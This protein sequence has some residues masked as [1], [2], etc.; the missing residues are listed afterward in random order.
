MPTREA[1]ST[2]QAADRDDDLS[3][4]HYR[5][6]I[7]DPISAAGLGPLVDDARFDV[8][9]RLGLKGDALADALA[10][11]DAV[12]VRSASRITREAL[13][14]A[15][16][17]RVIGRAGVGVDNIDVEAATERGIAVL[18][19]PSGNTVSA[20]ELAFALLLALARRVPAA[21]R[22]MKEGQWDRRS[23]GGIELYGKTLGLVGAGRIGAAVARR[24]K[25]F[26]MSVIAYDPFLTAERAE[27][28]DI[29]L[30]TLDGVIERG[31]IISLHVP[32]T[33]ATRNL[34]GAAELR[35][36]KP[37]AFIVNAARGGVV[38]EDALYRALTEG[39]I[40]GA[41]LDVFAEE[42]P[43]A[44]HP[45][46]SLPNVV[47]TPHLGAAT[48]E[49]QE[50]VAIE[51]AGAVRSALL[52]DDMSRAVNAPAIGGEAMRR[53]RPL[54]D[55][56]ER[57]G[58]LI[59]ALADGPVRRI[60]IRYSGD[61]DGALRPLTSAAMIGVL[62]G[63]LGRNAVNFVNAIHL[64][65]ARGI[66]TGTTLLG[67]HA[68]YREYVEVEASTAGGFALAGGALLDAIHPRIVRIGQFRVD[69]RP[70]GALLVLRN[71]DVPGVIGRVGTM[72]GVAGANI[73]EYHQS[74]L[75]QG[76]EALAAI[77]IDGWLSSETLA[78][79]GGL[80]EVLDVKQVD[81]D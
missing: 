40:A 4:A 2:V 50:N 41:A 42:P 57:L 65:E 31:D 36:M 29:E 17:L 25:A 73:A 61:A 48:R 38:D 23:L 72:L 37:S 55:L 54:L 46:R 9:E 63:V 69:V 18:N 44:D 58:R 52:Y 80:A 22:S 39:R 6:V 13:D 30:S 47:L 66:T 43:P 64:A 7:I 67:K 68:D 45:L 60:D 1:E 8:V 81:L 62:Q 74:R 77:S 27:A 76:G 33:D 14:R 3:D 75:I 49:A 12:I 11:A 51:I 10:D 16:R 32:L 70:R 26:G 53:L 20:A 71:R 35:R 5:V 28:L 59:Q 79:L 15:E 34:L 78:E 56:T 19:A 21:D 24:A